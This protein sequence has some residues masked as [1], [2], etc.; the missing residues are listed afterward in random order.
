[1][2]AQRPRAAHR[3]LVAFDL[4]KL[5][6]I[7]GATVFVGSVARERKLVKRKRPQMGPRIVALAKLSW[8]H[9][10]RGVHKSTVSPYC[11][12]KWRAI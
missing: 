12:A 7:L 3:D 10:F 9:E 2:L 11:G 6:A 1:M 5:D 8:S 4:G